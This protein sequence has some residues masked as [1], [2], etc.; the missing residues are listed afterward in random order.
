MWA[1]WVETVR[2]LAI[3]DSALQEQFNRLVAQYNAEGRHYHNLNHIAHL[4][5]TVDGLRDLARDLTAVRLAGWFHDIV[6]DS[7]AS[8]NEVRS[9][10]YAARLLRQWGVTA[11]RV[12]AVTNLIL[13]TR[14]HRPPPGDM[15]AQILLD[16][17][18]AILGAAPE[19][20]DLYARQIRQEYSWVPETI[21]GQRRRA[22]LAQFLER[23]KIYY[24]APMREKYER[25]ARQN[26]QREI[27]VLTRP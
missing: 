10:D 2:P 14:D 18:L 3:D 22:I 27:V 6:Y 12:T 7:R 9:A 15:D 13:A 25:R 24:T 1:R 8:D 5:E 23:E 26:I 4:L 20:Y 16:A 11:A 17:D 21:Y 19:R